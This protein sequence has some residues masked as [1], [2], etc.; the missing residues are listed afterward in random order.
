MDEPWGHYIK[1]TKPQ[2]NKYCVIAV[3]EV[4]RIAIETEHGMIAQGRG[5]EGMNS[6]CL[7]GVVLV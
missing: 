7:M 1:W 3:H 2:K 5:E 4:P 6:Y